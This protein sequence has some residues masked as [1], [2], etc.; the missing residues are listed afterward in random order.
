M[1]GGR[2]QAAWLDTATDGGWAMVCCRQ[3]FLTDSNGLLFPREWLKRQDLPL[4]AEQGLGRFGED[5]V[6]LLVVDQLLELPGCTWQGTRQLMLMQPVDPPTFQMLGYASQIATWAEQHRFCG[7]C[8]RPIRSLAGER[9][10]HCEPCAVTHYPRLSP[11]MI[12]LITRGEEIL[13][14]RSSRFPNGLYST[15]AGFVEPGESVE[16][17]VVR[18]V[19][20]EV[21]LEITNLQYIA[22][23][24]WPFPHSLMLGF[25]AQYLAGDIVPQPGEIEDAQWFRL[26]QL[27]QL[28][29]RRTIS[30]YLIDLYIARQTGLDEP[31][32]PD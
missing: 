15:L 8:G 3:S 23:Q 20:E 11:S 10:M 31:V 18:E 22:S 32:L 17:C 2:W 5:E 25:H 4:I 28:P 24:G 29:P 30:R 27:P 14:A 12:V 13:L 6:Y 21:G 26:D 1:D 7:S 9:G 16:H 19:R